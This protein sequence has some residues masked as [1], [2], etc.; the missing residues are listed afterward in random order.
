MAQHNDAFQDQNKPKTR[1]YLVAK[2]NIPAAN[3]ANDNSCLQVKHPVFC[4]V[5]K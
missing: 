3:P 5:P 1:A 2:T 4:H